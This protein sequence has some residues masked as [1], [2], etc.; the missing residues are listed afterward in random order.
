MATL[1]A[2][3]AKGHDVAQTAFRTRHCDSEAHTADDSKMVVVG[4]RMP[5]AL[6][7]ELQRLAK[8]LYM[9]QS[10]LLREG[11]EMACA[12]ARERARALG[13]R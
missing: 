1:R 8:A 12:W 11:A 6:R 3:A 10:V 13:N 9:T 4:L 7:Q 5:I 2:P